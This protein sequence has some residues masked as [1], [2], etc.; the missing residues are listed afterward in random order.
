MRVLT[1]LAAITLVHVALALPQ[2][3]AITLV[4]QWDFNEGSGT[5]V[6]D[7]SG[8]ANHGTLSSGGTPLPS[9]VAGA[10]GGAGDHALAFNGSNWVS[11]AND[12]ELRPS[13]YIRVEARIWVDGNSVTG[14]S[15]YILANT[16]GSG[17]ASYAL[18]NN[19]G[20]LRFYVTTENGAG[21]AFYTETATNTLTDDYWDS[22]WHH[23]VGEY[24]G[25]RL[26]LWV[27]GNLISDVARTG[28]L[29]YAANDIPGGD[30]IG[31]FTNTGTYNWVG[32]ID[33][34]KVYAT[35]PAG[36]VPEPASIALGILGLG[37][38]AARRVRRSSPA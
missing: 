28:N 22:A 2:S 24:N 17:Y 11:I 25:V 29:L 5:Q 19:G 10:S 16:P 7:S 35:D 33:D 9:W 34:V 30:P 8:Y 38:I 14:D 15:R 23:V 27:D 37:S 6:A 26:R 20:H 21:G 1:A 4:G 31:A 18:Y 36:A 13:D 12:T 32:K 3:R